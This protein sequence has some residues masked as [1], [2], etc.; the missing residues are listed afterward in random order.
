MT[1]GTL[2]RA[3]MDSLKE[4]FLF[5]DT[6]HIIRYMNKVAVAHY[7]QG[8][9]LIGTSLFDCHNSESNRVIE[10]VFEQMQAGLE[11]RLITD[12]KKHRIYM[13]A[14]RDEDGQ[15]L[16]YYERYEPPRSK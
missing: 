12:N 11:E 8:L 7:E 16:G 9:G 2:L 10:A 13:R 15:L 4:P 5:A 1:D 6:D 14:V 3:F